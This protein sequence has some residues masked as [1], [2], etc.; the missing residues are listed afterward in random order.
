MT[1]DAETV[2]ESG[3]SSPTPEHCARPP[4]K[5]YTS[6]LLLEWGSILELTGGQLAGTIDDGFSGSGGQ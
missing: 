4:G 3:S 5:P 2:S 1:K 6:P